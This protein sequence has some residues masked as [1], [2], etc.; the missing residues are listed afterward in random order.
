MK[1]TSG[2]IALAAALA[3]SF[4]QP[5][6]S[7]PKDNSLRWASDSMPANLD[8]YT[9][10]VREGIV[11]AHQIWD[12]LLYRN[13]TTGEL[14][15]NL[16]QSYRFIDDKTLEFTLRQGV[17]FHNGT[18][19]T[20][21]DVVAT[22]EYVTTHPTPQQ[23]S[24]LAGAEKVDDYTVRLLL[25]EP[26]PPVLEYLA[27]VL[28]IYPKQYY[29]EVGPE[30]MGRQPIG[31][32]PYKVTEIVLGSSVKMEA[33]ADYFAAAKPKPAIKY[34]EFRRIPEF[35]TQAVELM[36]GSLDWIWRVPPDAL[37]RLNRNASLKIEAGQLM[38]FAFLG[39]DAI[40]RSGQTPLQ[41]KR[42]RQAIN[43]AINREAI[44][45]ALIGEGSQLIH[46]M[47]S[48]VQFGCSQDETLAYDYNP[49]KAKQL[50]AQAG[51]PNGFGIDVNGYRD[52]T[53]LEAIMGDLAK[54]GIQLNLNWLQAS[55]V[56]K[57]TGEGKNPFWLQAWGSLSIQD[58]YASTGYWYGG[59]AM[60]Y[61]RDPRVLALLNGD[62]YS[63]D[64]QKRKAAYQQ[65]QRIIA[66]EAYAV[67]LFSYA[68]HYAYH[69]DL[70][71]TPAPDEI[72][73]FFEATWKK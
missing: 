22:V 12:G 5:A 50:L 54:V 67:P 19:F 66:E 71:F 65:A 29:A 56:I 1:R 45:A 8:F 37:P 36:T 17:K 44:R 33:F 25:K 61:A 14:E 48:P 27:N 59:S 46:T 57:Q 49:E 16:A 26:F 60:D 4:A 39:M 23:V 43:H 47:C 69:K 32:G 68:L 38:R 10:T 53:V 64:T 70:D 24:F 31:T 9:H 28:L 73:R 51:Y 18:I 6:I 20:A 58:A 30:G 40:G 3:L 15:P 13:N 7:G 42:V 35:N 62:G 52:R 11:L 41:D 21:D 2:F 72:P 63:L 34:Q 55:V